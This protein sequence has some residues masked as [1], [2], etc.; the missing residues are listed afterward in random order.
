[1]EKRMFETPPIQIKHKIDSDINWNNI[2]SYFFDNPDSILIPENIKPSVGQF[3]IVKYFDQYNIVNRIKF[4]CGI[5]SNIEWFFSPIL[6]DGVASPNVEVLSLYP[7]KNTT[8]FNDTPEVVAWDLNKNKFEL[9]LNTIDLFDIF[10]TEK[11]DVGVLQWENGR[12]ILNKNYAFIPKEIVSGIDPE[13]EEEQ[14]IF[15]ELDSGIYNENFSS[16]SFSGQSL[17]FGSVVQ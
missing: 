13:N 9:K 2:F 14:L 4:I 7:F 11:E 16:P 12:W 5:D 15:R 1:M 17:N 8:D 3:G 6:F 10:L